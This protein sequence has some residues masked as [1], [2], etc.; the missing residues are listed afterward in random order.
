MPK[1]GT[2]CWLCD[3]PVRFDTYRG[4]THAC[5]YCFAQKKRDNAE[6]CTDETPQALWRFIKGERTAETSWCDWNIPIHWGGM[7]DPFQP[8][9]RRLRR[10]LD[11]LKVLASTRYPFIVSTKGSIIMEPEY[12]EILEKCRC[13]V[14]VSAICSSYDRLEPG[15]PPFEKRLEVMREVSKAAQR[16]VVRVQPF[17]H[18]H[19]DETL[20][21]LPLFKEAGAYGIVVEGMKWS[22]S[23]QGLVKV[24]GDF[25]YPLDLISRD[26]A[27]LKEASHA[28]GLRFFAGENRLRAMGDSLTCCGCEGMEGFVPNTYNLNH[29]LRGDLTKPTPAMLESGSGAV[30]TSGCYQKTTMVRWARGQ[31]FTH[32]M[33]VYAKDNRE[34]VERVLGINEGRRRCRSPTRYATTR[35]RRSGS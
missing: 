1:C 8:V 21:S 12:T 7:S 34:S 15:A 18:G 9:E 35:S 28:N 29:I 19:L 2:Q 27:R 10:S 24:G 20:E 26:F 5:S 4:C 32:V 3:L 33:S 25:T 30:F 17:M 11:C 22:R 13:V 14:Q 23:G 16:L 31:T 6:V